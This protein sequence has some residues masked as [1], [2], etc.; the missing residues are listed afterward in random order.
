MNDLQPAAR[1]AHQSRLEIDSFSDLY[2]QPA[3]D[4]TTGHAKHVTNACLVLLELDRTFQQLQV[5]Y[6][7]LGFL[8]SKFADCVEQARALPDLE[9]VE[10]EQKELRRLAPQ[11]QARA[12]LTARIERENEWLRDLVDDL[13]EELAHEGVPEPERVLTM[14]DYYRMVRQSLDW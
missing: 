3:G 6:H 11:L 1:G 8:E 14:S 12:R 7:R 4:P 2:C 5:L 10:S 13:E 9:Q